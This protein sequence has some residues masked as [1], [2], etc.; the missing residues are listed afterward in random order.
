MNWLVYLSG[1]DRLMDIISQ[2]IPGV[3]IRPDTDGRYA[4]FYDSS[5][6]HFTAD[7]VRSKAEKKVAVIRGVSVFVLNSDPGISIEEISPAAQ[8]I[9][10]YLRDKPVAET[11]DF[12]ISCDEEGDEE[13]TIKSP[14]ES[15]FLVASADD[16]VNAAIRDMA[17]DFATWEGFLR[18]VRRIESC[19]GSP[20]A[21][22]W[23][24]DDEEAWFLDSAEKLMSEKAGNED[25]SFSPMYLSEAESFVTILMQEWI[26]EKKRELNI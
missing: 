9:S 21:K 22:G 13:I 2:A 12:I 19:E 10:E 4:L 24:S 8:N 20:A 15:V 1:E 16:C 14:F 25:E 5:G 17:D 26:K 3:L 23:C 6:G 11:E 18:I 7:A